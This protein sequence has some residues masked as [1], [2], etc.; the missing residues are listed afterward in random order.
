ME[1]DEQI[2]LVIPDC[3]I[4]KIAFNGKPIDYLYMVTLEI[5][6]KRIN[7]NISQ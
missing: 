5:S 4:G 3:L 1:K 7:P 6:N 2:D